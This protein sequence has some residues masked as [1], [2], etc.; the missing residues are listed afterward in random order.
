MA[1]NLTPTE[2]TTIWNRLQV[3]E[4]YNRKTLKEPMERALLLYKGEQWP[5]L[6]VRQKYAR[7]T[8]NYTMHVVETRVAT[9]AFRYP[10]FV[11]TPVTQ[12]G[13]DEEPIAQAAIKCSW[14]EGSVQDELRRV[15]KD[16]EMYGGGVWQTG[17]RFEKE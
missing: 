5:N 4:T 1:Y 3:G 15:A 10:R 9:I 17:G 11:L 2:V 16:E 13:E 12:P 6:K 8:A 7:F 14:R